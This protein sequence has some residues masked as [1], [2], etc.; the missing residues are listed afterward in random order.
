MIMSN[1]YQPIVNGNLKVVGF[2]VLLRGEEDGRLISG[3]ECFREISK[4]NQIL[5]TTLN[6]IS[7]CALLLE[8]IS[9][10]FFSVNITEEFLQ[11]SQTISFLKKIPQQ[12]RKFIHLE[13]LETISISNNTKLINNAIAIKLL[14][15]SF[16]LDDFFSHKNALPPLIELG[17]NSVKIDINMVKVFTYNKSVENMLRT[18]VFFCKI[19]NGY[20]IA[21]GVEKIETFYEL[22]GI[23]VS[24]FQGFLFSDAIS[25]YD[26]IKK[27]DAENQWVINI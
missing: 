14:G 12:K 25:H 1:Y 22:R 18:I 21:E 23:G 4:S 19:S 16:F 11:D 20:S 3:G 7:E 6:Q 17:I 15:F 27:Y 24:L 10:I 9:N 26:L 5:K 13:V 8:R 2:E